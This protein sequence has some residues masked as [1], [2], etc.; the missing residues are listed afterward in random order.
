MEQLTSGFQ[1][2]ILEFWDA[3]N[4]GSEA[5]ETVRVPQP[6]SSAQRTHNFFFYFFFSSRAIDFAD[7]EGL[8]VGSEIC[9]PG[10]NYR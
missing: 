10:K 8:L 1:L 2:N 5:H 9:Q 7:E 4:S 3:R 6:R